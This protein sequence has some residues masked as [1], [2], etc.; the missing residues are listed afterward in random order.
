MSFGTILKNLAKLALLV[1]LIWLFV[2]PRVTTFNDSFEEKFCKSYGQWMKYAWAIENLESEDWQ[3]LELKEYL[4]LQKI[5]GYETPSDKNYLAKVAN[6]WFDSAKT[7]DYL[8]GSAMGAILFVEC[9]KFG[10][11]IDEKYLKQ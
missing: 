11:K 7:G 9:E 8:T 6:Q 3:D 5:V 4:N 10:V 2:V 1:F